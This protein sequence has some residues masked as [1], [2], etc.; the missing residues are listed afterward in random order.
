MANALCKEL[1]L[2]PKEWDIL[3]HRLEASDCLADVFEEYWD[4]AEI[5]AACSQLLK[6]DMPGNVALAHDILA[7]CIEGTTYLCSDDRPRQYAAACRAFESLVPK[8]EQYI[9]RKLNTRSAY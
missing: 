6:G 4:A 5:D 7:D 8:I 2:T 9:N 3:K 1:G